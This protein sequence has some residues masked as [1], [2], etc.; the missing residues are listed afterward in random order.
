MERGGSMQSVLI[1]IGS[2]SDY[3]N[4]VNACL[5]VLKSYE[6]PFQ[7]EVTSAHRSPARTTALVE[8]ADK[9]GFGVIIAAAGMAA[10]LAGVCAAHTRLPV[11][12][13]P[14]ASGMLDGLD[15]LLSTAQMPPGVPVAA[16]GVGK[17]GAV[18]AAH[19]AARILAVSDSALSAKIDMKRESMAREVEEKG[20]A[21]IREISGKS[22]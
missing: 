16:F 6:I 4:G 5:D 3:K 19:L 18:N 10:H 12:G 17:S 20:A 22:Q 21:L 7:L 11:L 1:L 9:N 13:I 2:D 14:M 15:A 8:S